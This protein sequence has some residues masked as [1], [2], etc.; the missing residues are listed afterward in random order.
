MVTLLRTC[1]IG[2]GFAVGIKPA[3]ISLTVITYTAHREGVARAGGQPGGC[4]TGAC[5]R[6]RNSP[7]DLGVL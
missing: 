6:A 7:V 4:K 1:Q 2:N 3:D 5:C